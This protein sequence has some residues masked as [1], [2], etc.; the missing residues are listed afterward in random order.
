MPSSRGMRFN[1]SVL[2]AVLA[3]SLFASCSAWSAFSPFSNVLLKSKRANVSPASVQKS[4]GVKGANQCRNQL[5]GSLN[6]ALDTP[7][8]PETQA[9]AC[10]FDQVNE[11]MKAAMKSKDKDRL[12]AVIQ[13]QLRDP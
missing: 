1:H 6:M 2:H 7:S 12:S 3:A 13:L 11:N 4:W 10:I 8:K 9:G 5:L